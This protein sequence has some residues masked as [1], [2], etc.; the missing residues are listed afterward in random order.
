MRQTRDNL[1][2][3]QH[4]NSEHFIPFCKFP[5]QKYHYNVLR[6]MKTLYHIYIESELFYFTHRDHE[7]V[8]NKLEFLKNG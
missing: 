4:K 6:T 3:H 5:I 2:M 8:Y 1:F 7:K